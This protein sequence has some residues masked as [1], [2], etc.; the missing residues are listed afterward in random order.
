M[1]LRKILTFLT[2]TAMAIPAVLADNSTK[3]SVPSAPA[4]LQSLI[5]AFKALFNAD[6]TN[7]IKGLYGAFPLI[8]VFIVV[9]I[10]FSYVGKVTIFRGEED[11]KYANWLGIG[12]GLVALAIPAVFKLVSLLFGFIGFLIFFIGSM[13]FA[14]FQ[15]YYKKRTHMLKD[16]TQ[17]AR[18]N[19]ESIRAT[20]DL[21]KEKHEEGLEKHFDKRE[22][23]DLKKADDIA[24]DELSEATTVEE[25]IKQMRLAL[26]RIGGDTSSKVANQIREQIISKMAP[27]A[28]MIAN[29]RPDLETMKKDISDAEKTVFEELRND[30][31]E[32]ISL[33]DF[34]KQFEE[35][36]IKSGFQNEAAKKRVDSL[37]NSLKELLS[38]SKELDKKIISISG[39][40]KDLESSE[41]E[42][43][44]KINKLVREL[45]VSLRIADDARALVLLNE[46][47]SNLKRLIDFN[48]KV[49]GLLKELKKYRIEKMN[50]DGKQ[51]SLR[52]DLMETSSKK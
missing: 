14:I 28:G 19:K 51:E 43:V 31:H 32:F 24:R 30:K 40:A 21:N 41:L 2:G 42:D 18:A 34:K 4:A 46:I 44:D 5:D 13:I 33:D 26:G 39:R 48:N 15:I 1:K 6:F 17:S 12:L 3:A 8:G 27:F 37:E 16:K 29:L 35:Q 50:L 11:K 9:W 23:K 10:L 52:K 36:L 47:D 22:S 7:F 49:D 20:R 45:T 38:K 25:I